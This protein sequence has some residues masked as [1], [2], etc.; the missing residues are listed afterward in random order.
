MS[1]YECVFGMAG[2]GRFELTSASLSFAGNYAQRGYS[3]PGL[4]NQKD[5]IKKEKTKLH[6]SPLLQTQ[7]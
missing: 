6:S 7:A 5:K 4:V 1:C 2:N 3:G